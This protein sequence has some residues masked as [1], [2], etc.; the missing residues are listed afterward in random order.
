[1]QSVNYLR[2]ALFVDF[3]N[4]FISFERQQSEAA[5][6]FGSNPDRWVRWLEQQVPIDYRG[7]ERDNLTRRVLVRR[8]YINPRSFH[9]YRPYFIRSGFEVV[10]CPPL[11]SQ[12][13]T[14]A[15]IHMVVDMLDA[16]AHPTRFD[17]F[18]VF[19][20]DA[21]FTPVL[22]RLRKYDR[23]TMVLAVGPSS[24]AYRASSDHLLDESIFLEKGLGIED[25]GPAADRVLKEEIS[26]PIK[27][28]LRSI[29]SRLEEL[30]NMTGQVAVIDLP[31][32]YKKFPKFAQGENWLGFF[33]LRRMTEAVVATSGALVIV[34]E[35]PWWVETRKKESPVKSEEVELPTFQEIGAV[36][37]EAVG[38]SHSPVVLA[39]VAQKTTQKFGDQL[40]LSNWLG[41]GSFKALIERLELDNLRVSAVIPGF[42][43]DPE[44]HE[45]PRSL[46]ATEEEQMQTE[47]SPVA[48]K[49][50]SFTEMP[51]LTTSHYATVLREIAKE[52]NENGYHLT[53]TSKAVRDRCAGK[54]VPV[55]RSHIGFI[56][57][58]IVFSGHR[59]G[60]N[61][62]TPLS[63][64]EAL[65]KNVL[66]LCDRSQMDLDQ[67]GIDEVRVWILGDLD[68]E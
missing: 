47:A 6:L 38:T 62:E 5:E 48:R 63:L 40:R 28:V 13:K 20:G 32:V 23:R 24:P 58:G 15:D 9:E 3:D 4:I 43:F 11:T 10:D 41:T 37:K 56:L 16:L 39:S 7:V 8:C 64:G 52:V 46:V 36:V 51:H 12:G 26:K 49:V 60:A 42:V 17:E 67:R 44:R 14:S 57:K 66:D 54:G 2:S 27:E 30:A 61:P 31:G 55:A 53:R 50:S 29:A 35:D 34:D 19:S 25:T 18:I 1:M 68:R 21:D 65:F 33:S 59:F 22:L 45:E